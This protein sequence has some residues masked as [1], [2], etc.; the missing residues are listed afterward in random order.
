MSR[1]RVLLVA[2]SAI[3]FL[4]ALA[5]AGPDW[6]EDTDAGSLP[7]SA[8]VPKGDG[9]LTSLAGSINAV[10]NVADDLGSGG[11][12]ED[13]YAIFIAD[14]ALFGADTVVNGTANFDIQLFLFDEAGRA[15]LASDNTSGLPGAFITSMAND[16]TGQTVPSRGLYYLAVSGFDNDPRSAGGLLLFDQATRD[17]VS[18]P[19]GPGGSMSVAQWG[20]SDEAGVYTIVLTGVEF[21][22]EDCDGDGV[23]DPSDLDIDGDG[24][25]NINDTC[26][27][28]PRSLAS[29][30]IRDASH[31]LY[32]SVP[33]DLDGDCDCDLIDF[34]IFHRF[35]GDIGCADGENVS[36]AGCGLS[37]HE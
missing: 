14:P 11:D 9:P 31:P 30:I 6:V 1:I 29:R 3:V 20:S 28:T 34:S 16:G 37:V 8:Q 19:D 4:P 10:T 24:V 25:L 2:A 36:D 22:P 5:V 18:G 12:T 33:C 26:D 13:M 35:F 7:P 27:F 15:V 21:V 17:E 32:G 23:F